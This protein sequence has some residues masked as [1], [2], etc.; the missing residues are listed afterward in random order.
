MIN[1][2]VKMDDAMW[3]QVKR[4]AGVQNPPETAS[5]YVRRAIELRM[6]DD[7]RAQAM[8]GAGAQS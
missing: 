6:Q 8:L 2:T 5:E 1:R 7:A 3:E 4:H